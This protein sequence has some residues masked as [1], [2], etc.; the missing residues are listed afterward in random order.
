MRPARL[1]CACAKHYKHVVL[2]DVFGVDIKMAATM[3]FAKNSN[4]W[5]EAHH[6]RLNFDVKWEDWTQEVGGAQKS[7]I[8]TFQAMFKLPMLLKA[9]TLCVE[10]Q[11]MLQE[12]ETCHVVDIIDRTPH[13][14]GGDKFQIQSRYCLTWDSP[15]DT[16]LIVTTGVKFFKPSMLENKIDKTALEN[17]TA[18][19]M[20]IAK[21][22]RRI[23]M[24]L[25]RNHSPSNNESRGLHTSPPEL[26]VTRNDEIPAPAKAAIF[27]KWFAALGKI[28]WNVFLPIISLVLFCVAVSLSLH[29]IYVHLEMEH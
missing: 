23:A 5:K 8:I 20:E 10:K 27:S 17:S 7:R 1:Y 19:A 15:L 28:R 18:F 29:N 4:F 25:P 26:R 22:L 21:G 16:R 6:N 2:N 3:L 24:S 9:S 11:T 13:V 14:P 12:E